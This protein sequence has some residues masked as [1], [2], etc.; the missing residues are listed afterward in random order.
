MKH[1]PDPAI[2]QPFASCGV[3]EEQSVIRFQSPLAFDLHYPGP[4]GW[5]HWTVHGQR[6]FDG[7]PKIA[8][9]GWIQEG[10]RHLVL[11]EVDAEP[12]VFSEAVI[13]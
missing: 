11:H 4:L 5:R 9:A 7:M 1:V 13:P 2:R 12:L 3:D 6:H 8:K 10:S